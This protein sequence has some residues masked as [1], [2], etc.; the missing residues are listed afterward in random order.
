MR[1]H[2]RSPSRLLAALA[3]LGLVLV[4]ASA[5]AARAQDLW[6]DAT[7]G[8]DA[9]PGTASLPLRSL[10]AAATFANANATIYIRPGT[11]G[12]NATGE[13]LPIRF[14]S[15]QSQANLVIRGLGAAGS[16]V[17]DVAQRKGTV[18]NI[19]SMASGGRL[20][21][22][23]FTNM[24]TTDW[25]SRVVEAGTYQGRG[26]AT[27]FEIDRCIFDNVNRGLVIW[28]NTPPVTGWKVHDNL[29]LSL[30]NDAINE[31]FVGTDTSIYNNTI[32]GSAHLGILTESAT[33]KIHNNIVSGCREGISG[34]P[35][36]SST[37]VTAND[38]WMNTRDWAG[39]FGVGPGGNLNV[40]P[41]F[42]AAGT[43][44]YRLLP[45]SPLIDRGVASVAVRADLDNNPGAI[46]S[47]LNGSVVPDIGAY[48]L[49]PVQLGATMAGGA[50]TLSLSGTAG[51][52][53]LLFALDEG[54]VQIPGW[55]PFLLDLPTL[56]PFA[57]SGAIPLHV[58]IPLPPVLPGT[59]LAVQ[60]AVLTG[61]GVV[62][63][64]LHLLPL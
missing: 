27:G 63:S 20:T 39:S 54:L 2:S 7:L 50:L 59:T 1:S 4:L 29:F 49:N 23:R 12:P 35:M 53:F 42:A 61:T 17:F 43:G 19:G 56:F 13:L 57:L 64:N 37:N 8:N 46:D 3:P 58:A 26:S 9:N 14:G 47:D 5:S 32:V 62:P 51:G 22:I 52:G 33:A 18:I 31:F 25:W 16:V 38:L 36:A 44:N 40:D 10:T 45:A 6:V 60:G 11:Y 21:N 48:E 28:E 34:G 30:G 41:Q 15:S 55:S 24:D